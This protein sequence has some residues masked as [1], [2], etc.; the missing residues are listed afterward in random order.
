MSATREQIIGMSFDRHM[1]V[2][3]GAGSGKTRV[4]VQRF[5]EILDQNPG[6]DIKSIV[7]ITF[8]RKA[9]AEMHKRIVETVE[10]KIR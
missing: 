6:I 9:A 1:S 2:S 5:I 10:K 3:A 7:A 8:T 4:L